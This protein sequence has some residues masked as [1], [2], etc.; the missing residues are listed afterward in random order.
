MKKSEIL[1]RLTFE[2]C[3][4]VRLL[5]YSSPDS[6]QPLE[7]IFPPLVAMRFIRLLPARFVYG[8]IPIE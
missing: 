5:V 2:S 1:K 4:E 3:T 6:T 8:Y 7:G